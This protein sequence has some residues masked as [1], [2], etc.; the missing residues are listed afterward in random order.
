MQ[1]LPHTCAASEALGLVE[2]I[3]MEELYKSDRAERRLDERVDID[4][5]ALQEI[6]VKA[7]VETRRSCA[8]VRVRAAEETGRTRV[9]CPLR[10]I[11]TY[12]RLCGRRKARARARR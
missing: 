3:A 9:L 4:I 8:C 7:Q 2:P 1:R 10:R 6:K 11:L 12:G 5:K